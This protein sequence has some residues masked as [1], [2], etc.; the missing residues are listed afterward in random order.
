M[1]MFFLYY[2]FKPAVDG[3][4]LRY[5]PPWCEEKE[6]RSERKD[7]NKGRE[8]GDGGRRT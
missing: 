8:G 5:E 2:D 4:L 3:P 1:P 7:V 6:N